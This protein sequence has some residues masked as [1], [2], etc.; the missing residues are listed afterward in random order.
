M[1]I[2]PESNSSLIFQNKKQPE[3]RR[4]KKKLHDL[5]EK[6]NAENNDD[7][8]DAEEEWSS[9]ESGE[10]DETKGK[11]NDKTDDSESETESESDNEERDVSKNSISENNSKN[12]IGCEDANKVNASRAGRETQNKGQDYTRKNSKVSDESEEDSSEEESSEDDKLSV[13][14]NRNKTNVRQPNNNIYRTK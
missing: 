13:S 2:R 8:E 1:R 6:L 7:E 9:D 3:L 14:Q 10:K 5:E 12:K 11:G 4:L